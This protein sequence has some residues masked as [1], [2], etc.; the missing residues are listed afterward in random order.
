MRETYGTDIVYSSISPVFMFALLYCLLIK[1]AGTICLCYIVLCTSSQFC[2]GTFLDVSSHA[3]VE[4]RV[5]TAHLLGFR[6][7]SLYHNRG[8]RFM[9]KSNDSDHFLD[10]NTFLIK[11]SE[12]I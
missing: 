3:F 8:K 7:V 6:M 2:Y 12:I 4:H 1:L 9:S 10:E 5:N 11:M